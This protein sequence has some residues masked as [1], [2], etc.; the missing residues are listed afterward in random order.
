MRTPTPVCYLQ[1]TTQ[2]QDPVNRC[3]FRIL[4]K[5][6]TL[7]MPP[8]S[9]VFQSWRVNHLMDNMIAKIPHTLLGICN[10]ETLFKSLFRRGAQPNEF[11]SD[12]VININI[13]TFIFSIIE[14]FKSYHHQRM[15]LIRS[16]KLLGFQQKSMQST[17]P[18]FTISIWFGS[19]R[20]NNITLYWR[21]SSVISTCINRYILWF[22]T[23]CICSP[24]C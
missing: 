12:F 11:Y 19:S 22:C 7:Q 6:I 5:I 1:T 8:G 17:R 21:R 24:M 3:P 20:C 9:N 2:I 10:S 15:N 13:Q 16:V 14:S 4:P 23:G 18:R